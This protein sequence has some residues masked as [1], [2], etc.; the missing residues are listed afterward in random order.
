MQ[1][2]AAI[3]T[4]RL[5][6][7]DILELQLLYDL[8]TS[9]ANTHLSLTSMAAQ[10]TAGNR[11]VSMD[12]SSAIQVTNFTADVTPPSYSCT[13]ALSVVGGAHVLQSEVVS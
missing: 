2:Y 12:S 13:H 8:A 5:V 6:E 4:I 7:Q 1:D 10:D 11:V 3:V 9:S